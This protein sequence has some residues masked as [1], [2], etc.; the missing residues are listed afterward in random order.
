MKTCQSHTMQEGRATS[1]TMQ[2][3]TLLLTAREQGDQT[4]QHF[5][6]RQI[7]EVRP[8]LSKVHTAV[9]YEQRLM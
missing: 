8:T 4:L 9:Q 3:S 5:K 6:G 7:L 1:I 2:E